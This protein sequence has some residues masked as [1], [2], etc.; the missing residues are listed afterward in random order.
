MITE[1][2]VNIWNE[3]N[4]FRINLERA[5]LESAERFGEFLEKDHLFNSKN[6]LFDFNPCNYVDST[7][8]GMLVRHY[9]KLKKNEYNVKIVCNE[10][11]AFLLCDVSKLSSVID[12]F[13][14]SEKALAS[15][16]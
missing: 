6:I 14:D 5:T 11:V 7:F 15:F 16:K 3:I 10:K 1:F 13:T 9:I 2:E 4:I 12:V 8:L